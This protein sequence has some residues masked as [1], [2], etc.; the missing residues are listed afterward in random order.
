MYPYLILADGTE[1]VHSDISEEDGVA[2]VY[3][4]FERPSDSGFDSAR[5]VLPTYDWV[6]WEGSYTEDEKQFFESF[7]R[8]NAALLYRYAQQGGVKVA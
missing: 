4:H 6:D 7:L 1:V 5:C 3:V 8:N 2:K